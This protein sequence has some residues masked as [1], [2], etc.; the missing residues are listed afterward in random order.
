MHRIFGVVAGLVAALAPAS[1]IGLLPILCL[2]GAG[3]SG[4]GHPPPSPWKGEGR[5]GGPAVSS[6]T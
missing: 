3:A 4:T 5:G 6:A 1:A 2:A